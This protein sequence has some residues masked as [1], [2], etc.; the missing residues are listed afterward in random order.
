MRYRAIVVDK[1]S[2]VIITTKWFTKKNELKTFASCMKNDK[3]SIHTY[4][5]FNENRSGLSHK[6]LGSIG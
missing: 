6:Y 2:G 3:V 5:S 1:E 4:D